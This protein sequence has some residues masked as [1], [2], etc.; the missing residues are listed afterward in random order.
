MRAWLTRLTTLAGLGALALGSMVP[1]ALPAQAPRPAPV[2]QPAAPVPVA[3]LSAAQ[4]SVADQPILTDSFHFA[5]LGEVATYRPQ[6]KI[7]G[8]A[9]VLSGDGGWNLGVIDMAKALADQGVA[10]AGIS[11][12]ALQKSLEGNGEACVNPNFALSALAQDFEHRLG[13]AGYVKP[14]LVGYSSGATIA[15]TALAQA[16]GGTWRA[17]LSLGFGPD[18]GGTKP[19]CKIAGVTASRIAK[20]EAGWLFSAAP[21]LPA[22][23]V[24]FQGLQDQVVDPAQARAFT[25][26]I[27]EARLIELPKV[28]HGYSVQ[29]NW[30]PQFKAAVAPL[31][32]A[33]TPAPVLPASGSVA[34]LPLTIVADPAAHH[35]DVMAVMYSGD[36]GWAGIDRDVAARL[37]AA[38]VPVVG[39]DSLRYFW[40][41]KTPAGA[42]QDAARIVAHFAPGWHRSKVIFIGYSFGADDLAYIVGNLPAGVRPMVARVSMLGLSG[43][44]DFQ[45]H[46]A[47]WLDIDGDRT[48]PTAPAIARLRGTD[49]QCVRGEEEKD[50]AC[51]ALPVGLVT[52]I[53]LPGGHHFGGNADI[54][55]AA[56]LKGVVA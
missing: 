40:N 38:G 21:H 2:V 46:L 25:A 30:V 36:G 45:F 29:A 39:V 28:G 1:H 48:L 54:V 7:R 6:T 44:A 34:D 53:L 49:M 50:S 32:D 27:P 47:S 55:A 18:L 56:L 14:M 12:P 16:P 17:A 24:V 10:V 22:P 26:H 37:A 52:Q 8:V 41:A 20:P 15:Y 4:P 31:L 11:T 43:I 9:L 5:Q 23:W 3:A 33:A 51:P 13:M 35:S 42:G 19:W